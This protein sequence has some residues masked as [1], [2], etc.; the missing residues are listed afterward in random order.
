MH[1]SIQLNEA[2]KHLFLKSLCGVES[3]FACFLQ[4]MCLCCFENEWTVLYLY[5]EKVIQNQVFFCDE[6]LLNK[7]NIYCFGDLS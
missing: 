5:A 2:V 1:M 3:R 4:M 6:T 7:Q